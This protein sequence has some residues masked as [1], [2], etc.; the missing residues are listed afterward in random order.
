MQEVARAAPDGYNVV[1]GH[2]GTL[3]VNPAMFAKLPYSR[4]RLRARRAA[5]QG[6]D[7]VRG[8]RQG[9]GA[10]A[11]GIRGA[12]QGPARQAE[13][14]LRGQ[15]QRGPPRVRD[16]EGGHRHRRDARSLQGH[17]RPAERPAGRQHRRGL[18]GPAGLRRAREGRQ[19]PDPRERIAA[20]PGGA[21]E[22]AHRGRA[23]VSGLRQLAV[24]RDSCPR[25]DPARGGLAAAR[26]GGQGPERSRGPRAARGRRQHRIAHE[27]H[28]VRRLHQG[29]ARALGNVVR[30]AGLKT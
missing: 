25:Q 26:R 16:A 29:R 20:A 10:D 1:L 2:V 7:G 17:R 4:R 24:V 12:G 3:A 18:R 19:D 15:R 8:R 5:G 30:K 28:G 11:G 23:R 27:P 21:A 9:A 13:L 6:A 14:R 22:H